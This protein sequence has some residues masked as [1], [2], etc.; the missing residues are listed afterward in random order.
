MASFNEAYFIT[1]S[2]EKGY[3][4]DTLDTGGETYLGISRRFNSEWQG[5]EIIDQVKSQRKLKH[6]EIIDGG[7]LK[8]LHKDFVRQK[9]WN[10]INGDKIQNQHLANFFFDFYYHKPAPAIKELQGVLKIKADG[11]FGEATLD[12]LLKSDNINVYNELYKKRAA[13][14]DTLAPEGSAFRNGFINR[15]KTFPSTLVQEVKDVVTPTVHA[16]NIDSASFLFGFIVLLFATWYK[17][18]LFGTKIICRLNK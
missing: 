7:K 5:W 11:W 15:L 8:K 13:Y 4:N 14:Y 2:N 3:S 18:M 10:E 1:M 9:Y 16:G 17:K 12:S 6:C